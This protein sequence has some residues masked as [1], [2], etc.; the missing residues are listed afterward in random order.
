MT[1]RHQLVAPHPQGWR[2]R[3]VH[4]PASSDCFLTLNFDTGR[5]ASLLFRAG[6]LSRLIGLIV[7]L[8]M[9]CRASVVRLVSVVVDVFR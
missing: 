7:R 4:I 3:T 9:V 5:S 2:A 6:P 1:D 8:I